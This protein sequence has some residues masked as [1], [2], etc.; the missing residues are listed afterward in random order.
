MKGPVVFQ[1][2]IITQIAKMHLRN[3]KIFFS[4]TTGPISTNLGTKHPW[5]KGIQVCSNEEPINSHKVFSLFSESTLRYDNICLMKLNC[6]L[7]WA[8][9]PMGL[10]FCFNDYFLSKCPS[11]SSFYFCWFFD[12]YAIAFLRTGCSAPGLV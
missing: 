4:R 3:L 10:L 7:R 8:M 12:A 6:F 2:E 9:W 11:L 5:V 1:G